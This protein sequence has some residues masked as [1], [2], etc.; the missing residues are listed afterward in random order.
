MPPMNRIYLYALP[1]ALAACSQSPSS[2]RVTNDEPP[3]AKVFAKPTA[4]SKSEPV[5]YNG[6]TYKV[7]LS[8]LAG[9]NYV[10]AVSGMT[11]AQQKDATGLSTSAFHH[12]TC[13]DSQE[14]KFLSK[15]AFAGGQWSATVR[16]S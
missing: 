2:V 8:P 14:T 12:F 13:K 9:G 11:A 6:K 3:V 5:F 1:L 16:C 10:V 15:P 7:D 4:I